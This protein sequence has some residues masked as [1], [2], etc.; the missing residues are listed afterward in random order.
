VD[1]GRRR[2]QGRLRAVR[3]LQNLVAPAGATLLRWNQTSRGYDAA[4]TGAENPLVGEPPEHRVQYFVGERDWPPGFVWVGIYLLVLTP[5][6]V[7][8]LY[9]AGD[10]QSVR[11]IIT[12]VST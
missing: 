2:E 7:S 3:C 1:S 4:L 8:L 10:V 6:A 12:A 5:P 11:N 9:E